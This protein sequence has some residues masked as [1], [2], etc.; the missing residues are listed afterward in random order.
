MRQLV[1]Q[2]TIIHTT[3]KSV[4]TKVGPSRRALVTPGPLICPEHDYEYSDRTTL[5]EAP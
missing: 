5:D 2:D 1:A 3:A 4:D